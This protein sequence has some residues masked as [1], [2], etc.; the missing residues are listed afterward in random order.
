PFGIGAVIGGVGNHK[1][2]TAV[3]RS[4]GELFGDFPRGFSPD[5]ALQL[6]IDAAP[7]HQALESGPIQFPDRTITPTP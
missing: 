2:G 4:A 5:L 6:E 7:V 1:L 3:I